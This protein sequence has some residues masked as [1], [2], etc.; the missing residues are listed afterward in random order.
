M[1]RPIF[2]GQPY[3]KKR[4]TMRKILCAGLMI[5]FFG[6]SVFAQKQKPWTEWSKK[7]AGKTLNESPWGQTQTE[8]D[9]SQMTYSPTV[10]STTAVRKEANT[11]SSAINTES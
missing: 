3:S 1:A 5:G 6:A 10:T 2:P 7:E 8:T 11:I 9:T 4:P